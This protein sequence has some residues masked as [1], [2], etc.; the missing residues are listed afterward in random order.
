MSRLE[1]SAHVKIRP[2]QLDGFKKQAAE[3]I[4]LAKELDTRTLRYDWYISRDGTE[5][6]VKEAYE[7]SEGLIEHQT[8]IAEARNKLFAEFASDHVMTAYGEPSPELFDMVEAMQKAGHVK[9]TW[10]TFFQGLEAPAHV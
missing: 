3:I 8:H 9:I 5:C 4:R 1:L 2:G 6:E 10:F 7:S